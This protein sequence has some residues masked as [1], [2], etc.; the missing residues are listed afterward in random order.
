MA[1]AVDVAI[2]NQIIAEASGGF[3]SVMSGIM[4]MVVIGLAEVGLVTKSQQIAR[5]V[6]GMG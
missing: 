2:L 4:S 3:G 6:V 1:N 5:T